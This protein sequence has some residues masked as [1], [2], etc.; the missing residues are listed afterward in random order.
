MHSGTSDTNIA[1][2]Q[3]AFKAAVKR[4]YNPPPYDGPDADQIEAD[5]DIQMRPDGTVA[6]EPSLVAVHGRSSIATAVGESGKRAILQCQAY[7]FLPKDQYQTW[8]YIQMT[9]DLKDSS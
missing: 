6:V 2:W 5:V 4:C 7:T 3:G 8:K 1:T 9:F